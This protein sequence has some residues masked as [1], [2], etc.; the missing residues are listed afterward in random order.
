MLFTC[1]TQQLSTPPNRVSAEGQIVVKSMPASMEEPIPIIHYAIP[2]FVLLIVLELLASAWMKK[3]QYDV[4]DTASSISLGLGNVFVGLF[5]KGV[6]LSL[7]LLI[8]QY[9]LFDIELAWWSWGVLFLAEDFSYYWFH[10]I[11]H[12]SRYF[13]ASHVVHHTSER[14]NLAAALRQTWTGDLSGAALFW[15]WL[16]LI[17]FHPLMVMTM[18]AISLLYQF[19][20]HTELITKFPRW[21]EFIFNTPSHHRVHHASDPK[22]LDRNHAGILIIWDR[23][24][25]TFVQE[26]E[27]PTYGLTKNVNTF[28]PVKI[29]FHEWK[30][31]YRD[32]TQPDITLSDRWNYLFAPPGWSHDGSRKTS[33]QMRAE[34]GIE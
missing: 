33:A 21:F 7:M 20:I 13:W 11:S 12:S 25:G 2:G 15:F 8:Y 9:R 4:K 32:V 34:A 31:I 27:R 29:A 30:Q 23:M 10:R 5:V 16:P 18:Q 1:T 28:N 24:F 19:W 26:E 14:Y 3:D 22:Y 6:I 17:G